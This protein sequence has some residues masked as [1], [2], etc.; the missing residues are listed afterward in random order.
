MRIRLPLLLPTLAGCSNGT[1][2]RARAS[3]RLRLDTSRT[4]CT[5]CISPARRVRLTDEADRATASCSQYA[6][7][8]MRGATP[9]AG[10]YT[11]CGAL[12]PMRGATPDAG[13]YTRCGAL[14]PMRGATPD[15]KRCN[16][17]GSGAAPNATS[18]FSDAHYPPNSA[19]AHLPPSPWTAT[20]YGPNCHSLAV[21]IHDTF[22]GKLQTRL[23]VLYQRLI[24]RL[25]F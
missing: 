19:S 3:A 6:I 7:H 10:R 5:H 13:R 25:S 15:Q 16:A 4:R 9:D 18:I 12:H 20:H 17:H 23:F 21:A 8:P 24:H 11:R 1:H 14:H 2:Q 22:T